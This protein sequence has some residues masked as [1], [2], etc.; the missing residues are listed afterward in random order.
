[1]DLRPATA[2]DVPLLVALERASSTAPHW[3]E[4]QYRR[5]IQPGGGDPERLVLVA[6]GPS[7]AAS[8]ELQ[9]ASGILGFLV[10]LH[11]AREWELE[12]IV[13]APAARGKG[14]G[15][16]LLHALL[17]AAHKTGSQSVFLEV[18]ESNFAA[19]KLYETAGFAQTGRRK[20]YYSDPSE[21][22]ILYHLQIQPH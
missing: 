11:L 5:A 20:A 9:S 22:A 4:A 21:D 2:A 1:V 12:N 3:T 19:R 17:V 16:R 18:R 6:E 14:L 13:V 7:P 15:R 10:A 8:E